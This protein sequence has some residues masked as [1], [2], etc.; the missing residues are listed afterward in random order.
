MAGELKQVDFRN[1]RKAKRI[2]VHALLSNLGGVQLSTHIKRCIHQP[3]DCASHCCDFLVNMSF[4]LGFCRGGGATTLE[5]RAFMDIVGEHSRPIDN[6]QMQPLLSEDQ[7]KD[8][9]DLIC[10]KGSKLT[11][12]D[13][14]IGRWIM[15]QKMIHY[16]RCSFGP[17]ARF[18]MP[19]TIC[20]GKVI[21]NDHHCQ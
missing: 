14:G 1:G 12:E 5:N 19:S 21:I 7:I 10:H 13:N 3:H 15:E 11:D 20:V 6:K 2:A 9:F 4:F 17:R 8:G 18:V 16:P